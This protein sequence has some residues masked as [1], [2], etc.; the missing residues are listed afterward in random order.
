MK[1]DRTTT[2]LVHQRG[3]MNRLSSTGFNNDIRLV[4]WSSVFAILMM[5]AGCGVTGRSNMSAAYLASGSWTI[6]PTPSPNPT[7]QADRLLGVSCPSMKVCVAVGTSSNGSHASTTRP[8]A[9]YWDGTRWSLQ[10][11]KHPIASGLSAVS[12]P[13][14]DSCTA[15]GFAYGQPLAEHWDGTTWEIAAIARA[16]RYGG[17]DT[18]LTAVSC[19]STSSCVAV[20]YYREPSG[21]TIPLIER[22]RR[23]KWELELLPDGAA[24]NLQLWSVSCPSVRNCVA[25][26][27]AGTN[28]LVERWAGA[29][30][31]RIQVPQPKGAFASAS[32]SCPAAIECII[33]GSTQVG[34]FSEEWRSGTWSLTAVGQRQFQPHGLSCA[35]SGICMTVGAAQTSHGALNTSARWDGEKW[36]AQST[37]SP[38]PSRSGNR[39]LFAVSCSSSSA[40]IA[41]GQ[42]DYPLPSFDLAPTQAARWLAST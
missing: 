4:R 23:G 1:S 9:E 41:V 36:T 33:V 32:V 17:S 5:V 30:W 31:S 35:S 38:M 11:I 29:S 28:L 20:G 37:P 25:I 27:N 40:C 12:C 18:S 8:L 13:T 16:P 39:I 19:P 42:Q 7:T 26:G 21:G 24:G 14:T 22:L 15:V 10:A 3:R 6:L 2:R 34:P